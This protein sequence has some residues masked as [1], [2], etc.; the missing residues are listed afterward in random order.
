MGYS[1]YDIGKMFEEGL[2]SPEISDVIM[3]AWSDRLYGLFTELKANLEELC[4]KVQVTVPAST[5][6][7][8]VVKLTSNPFQ[9]VSEGG[10]PSEAVPV[11]EKVQVSIE[12]RS[13]LFEWTYE[14][15]EDTAKMV[16]AIEQLIKDWLIFDWDTR[17]IS[18]LDSA[19]L[20]EVSGNLSEDLILQAIETLE[21][22]GRETTNAVLAVSPSEAK[23]IRKFEHFIPK[24]LY[25]GNLE[26]TTRYE[27]GTHYVPV[28]VT[29]ALASGKAYLITK[30]SILH[31]I[32]RAL[33]IESHKR[34]STETEL[35]KASIRDGFSIIDS[36]AIVRI[37]IT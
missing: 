9:S 33:S 4:F 12:K 20:T 22:K 5:F 31:A 37:L 3:K 15:R 19:T 29:R 18:L 32:R 10:T 21:N 13:A 30:N 26:P 16:S 24:V 8:P 1:A 25:K 35:F 17:I 34:I 36:D 7:L 2:T 6:N 28:T 14:V 27:I 23:T 11:F